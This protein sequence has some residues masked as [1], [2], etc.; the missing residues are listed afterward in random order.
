[1]NYE[2]I[3]T[4]ATKL[5]EESHLLVIIDENIQEHLYNINSAI[6][7][8]HAINKT[9]I[10]YKLPIRFNIDDKYTSNMNVQTNVYYKIMNILKQKNYNVGFVFQETYVDLLI[11]WQQNVDNS[12]LETM[13]KKIKNSV[14]K[15]INK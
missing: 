15:I 7:D 1:M 6:M 4:D 13:Q 3:L 10:V 5:K 11:D 2:S 12:N 14:I 9:C 8:A